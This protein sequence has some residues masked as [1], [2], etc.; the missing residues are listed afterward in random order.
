MKVRGH[1]ELKNWKSAHSNRRE[2]VRTEDLG[3]KFNAQIY[4]VHSSVE[5]EH[6][7]P[8]YK[9]HHLGQSIGPSRLTFV[10]VGTP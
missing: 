9:R 4:T 10:Q 8:E 3:V 1:M 7:A 6:F 5:N 2:K